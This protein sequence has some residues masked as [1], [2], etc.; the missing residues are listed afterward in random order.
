MDRAADMVRL[1]VTIRDADV[2]HFLG[3]PEGH[4]PPARTRRHI[5]GL[6]AEARGLVD[7]RGT[8]RHLPVSSAGQVD[9]E[10]IPATGLV[11]GLVTVGPGIETRV[12]ELAAAGS[13]AAALVLDAMGSAA[14]EEAADRLGAVVTARIDASAGAPEADSGA[15][16]AR[17]PEPDEAVPG[18]SCRISPGFGRWPLEAQ[19]P[20]FERLP[21]AAVGVRLL[22]S[23]LMVPRKSISFAMW[24]GSEVRPVAGLSGCD[25]CGLEHCRY[26]RAP[27]GGSRP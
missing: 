18:P 11:I 21:H 9:L 16:P 23:L 24:L 13:A 14:V 25:R 10:P 4:R 19:V 12:T 26:R 3:Y 5:Q 22:P 1:P 6:L 8:Y 20:L 27:R 7:A 17:S 15:G 2:L